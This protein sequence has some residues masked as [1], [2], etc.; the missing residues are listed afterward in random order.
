[1]QAADY[2][3]LKNTTT[4]ITFD[5]K[6]WYLIDYDDSTVTLLSKEC[7]AASQY[8]SNGSRLFLAVVK[9]MRI[10]LIL[11]CIFAILYL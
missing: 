4:E 11:D 8:N 9:L 5:G 6:P 7:V 10:S 2:K 1:M 3:S